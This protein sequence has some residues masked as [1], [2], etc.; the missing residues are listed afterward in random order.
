MAASATDGTAAPGLGGEGRDGGERGAGR[1]SQRCGAGRRRCGSGACRQ[2]RWRDVTEGGTKRGERE[3]GG[4]R[5]LRRA[6]RLHGVGEGAEEAGAGTTSHGGMVAW[7]ARGGVR[8]ELG[9]VLRWA[10]PRLVGPA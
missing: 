10:G 3:V 2:W 8:L 9:D 6:G 7:R 4:A 5:Y 1:R